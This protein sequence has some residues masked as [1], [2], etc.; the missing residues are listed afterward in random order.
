MKKA[1]IIGLNNYPGAPLSGCIRDAIKMETV[2]EK[3]GDGSPNFDIKLITDEQSDITK[4]NI[5]ES[6]EKLFEGNDD[7]ALLYFSGHGL[8]KSTGGYI[9]TPDYER[10]DEG[11]SMDEILKIKL[12]F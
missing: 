7:V 4:V 5:K 9:V 6:I 1:L 2:L 8:I 10:Y 12:S 11:I 3:N